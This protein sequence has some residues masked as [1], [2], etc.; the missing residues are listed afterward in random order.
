[1]TVWRTLTIA[2][3]AGGMLCAASS[4]HALSFGEATVRSALG[5]RLVAEIP[6]SANDTTPAS[7]FVV[8][9]DGYVPGLYRLERRRSA[10]IIRTTQAFREP[11]LSFTLSASCAGEARLSRRYDLFVDPASRV[12]EQQRVIVALNESQP[13]RRSTPVRTTTRRQPL[14]ATTSPS[15]GYTVANGDTLWDI[16]GELGATGAARWAL[17]DEIV[18]SNPSAFI[19]GD[20]NRLIGGA[21]LSLPITGQPEV[22][23]DV[24]EPTI[25]T[26]TLEDPTAGQREIQTV[27]PEAPSAEGLPDNDPGSENELAVEDA[28]RT[29]ALLSVLSQPA[30]PFK[31]EAAEATPTESDA[32]ATTQSATEAPT[33]VDANAFAEDEA[34]LAPPERQLGWGARLGALLAGICVAIAGYVA[35]QLMLGIA[36]RKRRIARSRDL[37]PTR[38]PT[39]ARLETAPIPTAARGT[40]R[41]TTPSTPKPRPE[42]V[43]EPEHVVEFDAQDRLATIDYEFKPK[44]SPDLDLEIGATTFTGIEEVDWMDSDTQDL[45]EQDYEAEMTRTQQIQKELAEAA[46]KLRADIAEQGDATGSTNEDDTVNMPTAEYEVS[47]EE[48]DLADAAIAEFTASLTVE[49]DLGAAEDSQ[50]TASLDVADLEATDDP[51]STEVMPPA[52]RAGG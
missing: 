35:Y 24:V 40:Q 52:K 50:R 19:N 18:A 25:N 10:L 46:L 28:Q 48:L 16:A 32:I 2:T 15:G 13:A 29:A 31:T 34:L 39:P 3:I 5:E 7:C 41:P 17:I 14:L 12:S 38:R 11:L 43:A 8:R 21:V 37:Q 45:L 36:A 42:Y 47:V 27:A 4:A 23:A 6:L 44:Q 33:P 51:D 9:G 22:T 20:A 26:N 49:D 30:S 1:M